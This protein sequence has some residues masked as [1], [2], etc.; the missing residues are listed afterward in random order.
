E[1]GQRRPAPQRNRFLEILE[2]PA[3]IVL[4]R[5]LRAQPFEAR[6]VD[7]ARRDIQHVATGTRLDRVVVAG[8][9]QLAQLRH[10]RLHGSARARR[11]LF[12]PELLDQAI[13]GDLLTGVD[14]QVR[15]EA[16]SLRAAKLHGP[17]R[18]CDL[19]RAKDPELHPGTHLLPATNCRVYGTTFSGTRAA[20][21][22]RR[23]GV[24]RR[25]P[26]SCGDVAR[27]EEDECPFRPMMARFG[28]LVNWGSSTDAVPIN[29]A[30]WPRSSRSRSTR[31]ETPCAGR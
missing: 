16:A 24:E 28:C 26:P 27:P 5:G 2:S 22:V 11:R 19:E 29:W 7:V 10:V 15:E 30:R 17:F 31:S 25:L 20:S 18:T 14:H 8:H 13:G 21:N 1:L 4:S 12:A 6:G 3:R 9:K 23:T